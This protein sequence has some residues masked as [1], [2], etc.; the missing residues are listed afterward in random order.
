MNDVERI[1][2]AADKFL[3]TEFGQW[4]I[5]HISNMHSNMCLGAEMRELSLEQKGLTIERAGGIKDVIDDLMM[6][7]QQHQQFQSEKQKEKPAEQQ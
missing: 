6:Y 5:Q 7:V 2:E 3:K 4:Y 1:A